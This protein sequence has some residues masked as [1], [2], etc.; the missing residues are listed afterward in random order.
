MSGEPGPIDYRTDIKHWQNIAD[1]AEEIAKRWE[2]RYPRL[3]D[4]V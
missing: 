2:R 4:M 1:Q 3:L